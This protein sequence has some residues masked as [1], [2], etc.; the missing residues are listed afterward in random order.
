MNLLLVQRLL[1]DS[2]ALVNEL[3]HLAHANFVQ[4][5]V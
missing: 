1:W 3:E 4:R 2:F 5:R